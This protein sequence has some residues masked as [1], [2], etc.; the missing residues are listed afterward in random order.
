MEIH[1]LHTELL[2]REVRILVVGCGGNG[3]A[4]VAGLP[5]LHSAMLAQGHPYGLHVTVMDGDTVSPFNS[6]RQPF[7]KSEVG[8]NK[9]IVL[10]NR[11]NI[12]WGLNWQ[13]I[14]QALKAQTLAPS[15]AGYGESHLRPDIVI[16][17]VDTRAARAIIA[18]AISG[19]SLTHYWLD[20]A[21]SS[22]SGQFVLGEPQNLRNKRSRIRLRTVSELYP[23]VADPAL[24][25]E[26]E[27]SC[28]TIEALERQHSFVNGVLAQHAL[29]L[30]AR[31][32]RDGQI[33]HH[34]GFVDV[35]NSRCVPLLVDPVLW[36]RV[37]RR[38]ARTRMAL[39]T[40]ASPD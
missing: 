14:P 38:R 5:Y 24:D 28:S 17:C 34:G 32:F 21:N 10:V 26:N 7:A 25:D 18:G 30:V 8:I 22:S 3:S 13:A 36:R 2:E 35:A 39:N 23:E 40:G 16:G 11:I 1:R 15:Y 33:S 37:V 29:A 4:I 20:V 27:P 12:F 9:A 6:V 31:L 19:S